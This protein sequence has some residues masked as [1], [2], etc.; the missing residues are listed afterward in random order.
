MKNKSKLVLIISIII[1]L[2]LGLIYFLYSNSKKLPI[3][4]TSNKVLNAETNG[5]S[6]LVQ[7]EGNKL[8]LKLDDG[9]EKVITDT[10]GE[11]D[12]LPETNKTENKSK[13]TR[14][15]I[16]D[17]L[18]ED[19]NQYG[20]IVRYYVGMDKSN[21]YLLVNK[22]NGNEIYLP[23]EK[24]IISPNKQRIVSY[25]VDLISGFT[26]NGFSILNLKEGNFY[27]E[28]EYYPEDWGPSSAKWI[29]DKELEFGKTK[30]NGDHD[31]EI[32]GVIK[33]KISN[34]KWTEV[35]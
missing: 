31:E 22:N 32:A 18:Y 6:E 20:V 23:S 8:I 19:I 7:K 16:F 29:N 34:N 9:T 5:S 35:K 28:Y 1:L 2:V 11:G 27:K 30:L 12:I 33:F 15:Y 26:T 25:N 24:I 10:A 13:D 21:Y 14:I 17:K 3:N 4:T